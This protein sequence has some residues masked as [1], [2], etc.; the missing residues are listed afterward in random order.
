MEL[1]ITSVEMKNRRIAT[2]FHYEIG[3]PII[4]ISMTTNNLYRLEQI[5]V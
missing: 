3:S 1:V 4:R 5:Q 2:S